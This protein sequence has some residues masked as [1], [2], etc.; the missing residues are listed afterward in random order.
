VKQFELEQAREAQ[1]YFLTRRGV[2]NVVLLP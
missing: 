1:E 2:G